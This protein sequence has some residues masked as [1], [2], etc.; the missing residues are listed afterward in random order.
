MPT[1]TGTASE[2][3][4]ESPASS[5]SVTVPSD[6]TM[7]VAFWAFWDSDGGGIDTLSLGGS[8][9]TV[10]TE[11]SVVGS[12]AA[13]GVATL[14][15][16][17]TGS[18]TFAWD[19]D[20]TDFRD[21]GGKMIL[22][23]IKDHNTTTPARDVDC[24]ATAGGSTINVTIDTQTTDLVIA[25]GQT[26]NADPTT[27]G[28]AFISNAIQ[29]SERYDATEVTALAGT[30]TITCN[31]DFPSVAA[32]SLPAASGGPITTTEYRLP[33]DQTMTPLRWR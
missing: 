16:P 17:P 3:N 25:M 20:G 10:L 28:T 31:G 14:V 11:I 33:V 26:Y 23:W 27:T 6:A 1:R 32:I 2:V 8:P 4:A 21:E 5:T 9:L 13:T 29:N 18:Q 24:N 22:V 15:A 30:T 7:V 12:A 19:W